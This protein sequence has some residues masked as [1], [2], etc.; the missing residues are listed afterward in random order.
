MANLAS[1]ESV[2]ANLVRARYVQSLAAILATVTVLGTAGYPGQ[3]QTATGGPGP[4]GYT[5]EQLH[6]LKERVIANQH[7]DDVAGA[8]YEHVEHRVVRG[9]NGDKATE[10]KVYRVVPTGTGVLKLV[11]K[12]GGKE[13]PDD[14]YQKELQDWKQ[15]LEVASDPDDWRTKSSQAKTTKRMQDRAEMVDSASSALTFNW[16]RRESYEGRECDVFQMEPNPSYQPH[17]T[18][19]DIL[20]HV[21]GTVWM[22]AKSE[23][24]MR[25]DAEIV[26]DISFGGGVLAKIYRGGHFSLEQIEVGPGLWFPRRYQ[27]DYT[28]RK[29]F[30]SFESH[31]V[32]EVSG[33]R[34]LGTT[35]EVLAKAREET[36]KGEKFAGDP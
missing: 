3:P 30:F 8:E 27:L 4:S 7:K 34:R 16:V 22:D 6:K 12:D 19:Q 31:V 21:R 35:K 1:S 28:G 33:Y 20:S 2:V 14:F 32:T 17:T 10:D 18:A 9:A 15:Q 24:M 26:R 25:V 23:Q 11:V 5:E 13:V 36:S 29:F